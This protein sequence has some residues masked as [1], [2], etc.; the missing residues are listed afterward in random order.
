MAFLL[1]PA[2]ALSAFGPA[3]LVCALCQ[4]LNALSFATDGIHFGTADYTY[5]RNGMAAATVAAALALAVV[6]RDAPTA[7]AAIWLASA[8]W[9]VIRSGV[10]VARIW[11]GVGRAPLALRD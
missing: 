2:S 3:W 7:L 1:V 11:P 9:S 8:L 6:D 10:G 4:P 5:L